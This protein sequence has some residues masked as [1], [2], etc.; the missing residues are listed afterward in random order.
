MCQRVN[1]MGGVPQSANPN[2]VTNS[3]LVP[4][5]SAPARLPPGIWKYQW[6]L[7]H[8]GISLATSLTVS[9]A[10]ITTSKPR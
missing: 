7:G 6:G 2:P 8:H 1:A 10:N 4:V 9:G 5:S 3:P